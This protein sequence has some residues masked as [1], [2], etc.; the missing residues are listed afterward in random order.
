MPPCWLIS[1]AQVSSSRLRVSWLRCKLCSLFGLG[2]FQLKRKGLQ[3]F[4]QFRKDII[5]LLN[6]NRFWW[7]QDY[8]FQHD[9]R[10][11]GTIIIHPRKS[12]TICFFFLAYCQNPCHDFPFSLKKKKRK[13][14]IDWIFQWLSVYRDLYSSSSSWLAAGNSHKEEPISVQE[15]GC[16]PDQTTI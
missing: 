9:F 2:S 16:H 4:Q 8:T 14:D 7:P 10:F 3:K 1:G 13:S 11:Y 5:P 15:T 12:H 6:K